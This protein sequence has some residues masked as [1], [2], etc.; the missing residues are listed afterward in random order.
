MAW[1][2]TEGDRAYVG[3]RP[4]IDSLADELE[5]VVGPDVFAE[6]RRRLGVVDP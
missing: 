5:A 4:V 1:C 2:C 6:L 3:E